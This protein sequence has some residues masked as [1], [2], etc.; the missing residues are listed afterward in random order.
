MEVIDHIL[1]PLELGN[2]G[3]HGHVESSTPRGMALWYPEKPL[4]ADVLISGALE[5]AFNEMVWYLPSSS[6]IIC[7]NC[8]SLYGH[9]H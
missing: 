4:P 8:K 9:L 3:G 7:L 1:P 5:L 2:T 6:L